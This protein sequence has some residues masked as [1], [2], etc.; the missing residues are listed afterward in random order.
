MQKSKIEWTNNTY[1]PIIVKG[2]GFYCFK[3][4]DACTHCYAETQARRLV[5]MIHIT[6]QPYTNRLLFPEME[7]RRDMLASWA[8]K[9]K[10]KMNFVSSMTD[11]FGEFVPD[12][13]VFEILDAMVA[14]PKQIFQ[15]LTKRG[16]RSLN[17]VLKWLVERD[18][19]ALPRNIWFGMTVEHQKA[20]DLLIPFLMKV[21]AYTRFLSCEPLLGPIDICSVIRA[22]RFKDTGSFYST[23]FGDDIHWV[24]CGG[25]SGIQKTIRPMHPDW[26]RSLRDQCAAAK[27]PFFFKQWGEWHPTID[28]NGDRI[29]GP[30]YGRFDENKFLPGNWVITSFPW[31]TVYLTRCGKKN[32]GALLD[33]V[34]H[35]EFPGIEFI[36]KTVMDMFHK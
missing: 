36:F 33:G 18:R 6:E 9:T 32:S 31:E 19:M 10:H 7:L 28:Y 4:S 5:A 1:N 30:H 2:G 34:E 12:E 15:I 22:E 24:I 14:A 21:P 23:Y 11:I 16:E 29:A 25:E 26:A 3:V 27:V 20:A 13:F 17:L 8:K 35:K